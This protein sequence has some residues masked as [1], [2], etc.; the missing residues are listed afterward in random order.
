MS[1]T[2]GQRTKEER[3][4]W[5]KQAQGYPLRGK[6]AISISRIKEWY[7]HFKGMVYIALSGGKDS[8]AM[9]DLIWSVFPDVPAVFC[10]TGNEFQSV[11]DHIERMIADGRPIV[12]IKPNTTFTEVI[13]KW[14]YPVISKNTCM[15]ID[16]FVNT[17]SFTQKRL[18]AFG[19]IN[20][21][22]GKKQAPTVRKKWHY[23][24]HAVLRGEFRTTNKCC[25]ILKINPTKPYEKE[26]GR[27]PF[28][29]TMA[30]E[31]TNREQSYADNGCNTF[32][33]GSKVSRPIMFWT[34]QDVLRYHVEHNLPIAGAYGEIKEQSDG[35]LKCTGDQ[36]TGCK[37]CLFGIHLEKGENRIQ[38]LARVEP[39]SYRYAI[40]ELGYDKVMDFLGVEWRPFVQP[41]MQ[42]DMLDSRYEIPVE[43][44]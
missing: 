7:Y 17:K 1:N 23:V 3:R 5:L 37:F 41:D 22:S 9:A 4:A 13:K 18:R 19:G 25:G 34:E 39:E 43:E 28:V 2:C 14:G 31:S 40:E 35:T 27:V 36:R 16:R 29:G 42:M 21:T 26:T 32:D 30:S 33:A 44:E 8:C 24:L 15:G 10:D 6:E 38:R 12:V 11:L 20:P